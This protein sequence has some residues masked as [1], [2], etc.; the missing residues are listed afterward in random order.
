MAEIQSF[1]GHRQPIW[2]RIEGALSEG[3]TQS[4][5]SDGTNRL[6]TRESTPSSLGS[7]HG[8]WFI[9]REFP[10]FVAPRPPPSGFSLSTGFSSVIQKRAGSFW[11]FEDA[12]HTLCHP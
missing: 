5:S 3:V 2:G 4:L 10:A 12:F 7:A 9:P 11:G 1:C 8:H 6:R